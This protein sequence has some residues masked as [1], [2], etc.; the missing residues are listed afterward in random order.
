[1]LNAARDVHARILYARGVE[2]ALDEMR[3]AVALARQLEDP[4]A[5]WPSLIGFASL[6]RRD[7][8]E[9][10]RLA[11]LREV[12]TEIAANPTVGD[13]Q[14]WH[15][16]LVCELVDAGCE[17]EARALAQR[18]PEGPWADACLAVLEERY[19][20]AA[21]I[22]ESVANQPLQAEIRTRAARRL[23]AQGRSAE[24]RIQ[25]DRARA[26]WASVDASAYLRDTDDLLLAAS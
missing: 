4:Q 15:I 19:V 5:L 14:E 8:L 22:L 6:A 24:A 9:P 16:E 21:D 3:S 10:E 20:A 17:R 23:A 18:V 2:G 7:G 25:L 26:F 13:A 1:M 11:T 12:T